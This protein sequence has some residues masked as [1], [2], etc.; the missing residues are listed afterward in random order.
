MN[1][2]LAKFF[3]RFFD[4]CGFYDRISDLARIRQCSPG[5]LT[6]FAGHGRSL[7]NRNPIFSRVGD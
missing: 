1:E 6:L 4:R 7:Q 2:C 5:L 3:F